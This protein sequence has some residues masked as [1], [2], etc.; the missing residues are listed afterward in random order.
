M[1]FVAVDQEPSYRPFSVMML[2]VQAVVQAVVQV[3][4]QAAALD[5]LE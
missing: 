3:E 5:S 4:V 1:I 2:P